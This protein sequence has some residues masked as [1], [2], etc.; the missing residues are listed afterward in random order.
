MSSDERWCFCIADSILFSAHSM[1]LNTKSCRSHLAAS[2]SQRPYTSTPRFCLHKAD[3]SIM[4]E[5]KLPRLAHARVMTEM[6]N[7]VEPL[8]LEKAPGQYEMSVD[9]RNGMV[10]LTDSFC[11]LQAIV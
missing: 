3:V 4:I 7:A 9:R 5:G 6:C 10:C 2:A 1:M 8:L 11:S